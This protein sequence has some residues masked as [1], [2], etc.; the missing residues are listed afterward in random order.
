MQ[1][2]IDLHDGLR[3]RPGAALNRQYARKLLSRWLPYQH[4][5][6]GVIPADALTLVNGGG[7]QPY[8][9][10]DLKFIDRYSL[11]D[12]IIAR[13]PVTR[14]NSTRQLAHDRYPPL[15]YLVARG[16]NF[17]VYP[18]AASRE[19]ALARTVYAVQVGS[20]LWMPVGAPNLDWMKARFEHFAYDTEA[21]RRFKETLK[22]AQLLTRGPYDVY[23]DGKYLLYVNDHCEG[24]KADF[25]LH[26]VPSD[27]ADLP[28]HR[29]Q[30]GVEN[31][32]FSF[33][34]IPQARVTQGYV[35][36]WTFPD[37]PVAA[38]RTG[39]FVLSGGNEEKRLWDREV[40]FVD[41]DWDGGQDTP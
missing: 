34:T 10:A 24:S 12:A 13:N 14:P 32:D 8:F 2:L 25:F 23:L 26:V 18:A 17:A 3:R 28:A 38:I 7:I 35:A 29:R 16:V 40:R 22:N 33:P 6:R 19:K 9:I 21:D 1:T 39:Q 11:T 4:M 37:Y 30:Y 27:V 36:R 15:G 41:G 5:R 20:A 31:L